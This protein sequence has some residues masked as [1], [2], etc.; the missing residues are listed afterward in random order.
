MAGSNDNWIKN[1]TKIQV[2]LV[3]TVWLLGL[4]LL[5][6]GITEFYKDT[7][8]N[9]KFVLVYILMLGSFWTVFQIYYHYFSKS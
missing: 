1:P 8:W 9:F 5:S 6:A 2:M 3:T 4:F 7:F